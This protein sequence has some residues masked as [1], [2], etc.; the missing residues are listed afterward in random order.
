MNLELIDTIVKSIGYLF[1]GAVTA[2]FAYMWLIADDIHDRRVKMKQ[3]KIEQTQA[4][5]ELHNAQARSF[6]AQLALATQHSTV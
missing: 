1:G 2:F 5:T 3:L 4:D 6:E